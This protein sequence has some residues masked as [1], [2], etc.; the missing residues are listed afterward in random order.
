MQALLRSATALSLYGSLLSIPLRAQ[1]LS[2][3]QGLGTPPSSEA[4]AV[5]PERLRAGIANFLKTPFHFRIRV[6]S[7]ILPAEI[8]GW[9]AV[10]P[11]NKESEATATTEF[12]AGISA[13]ASSL[14]IGDQVWYRSSPPG[15]GYRKGVIPV[16]IP[17]SIPWQKIQP[18]LTDVVELPGQSI[19]GAPTTA[20]HFTVNGKGLLDLNE[21]GAS[22][23]IGSISAASGTIY[24]STTAPYY[25]LRA[26]LQETVAKGGY[27]YTL[28]EVINYENWG[29]KIHLSP[30]A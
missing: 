5:L 28:T 12:F 25:P 19:L 22:L 20:F 17:Q 23:P 1:E 16:Q 21:A 4:P 13:T 27:Q 3:T 10:D 30:P 14:T 2:P 9:G 7:T 11:L 24:L 6:T 29:A 8:T 15:G 26:V 18:Y